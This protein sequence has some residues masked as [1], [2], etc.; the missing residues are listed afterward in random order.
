MN[1]SILKS[2]QKKEKIKELIGYV[3]LGIGWSVMLVLVLC[4]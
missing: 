3:I 4:L 1:E 2:R